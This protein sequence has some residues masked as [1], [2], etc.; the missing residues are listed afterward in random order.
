[1]TVQQSE[2][3]ENHDGDEPL[4]ENRERNVWKELEEKLAHLPVAQAGKI[5]DVLIGIDGVAR[6]LHDL[7]PANVSYR[8][9]FDLRDD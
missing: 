4:K 6:S 7:R 1:M 9:A 2:N 8:R 5:S 3:G